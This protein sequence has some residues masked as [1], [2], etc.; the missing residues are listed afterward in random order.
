LR[1]FHLL[2]ELTKRDFLE[3]YVGSVLGIWWSFIWPLVNIFIYTVIFSKVMGAKLP[4]I[5][6]S[7]GYGF[8]LA[9]GLIPWTAFSNSILRIS[10]VFV[11]KSYII[12]KIPI[13]LTIFP[14]SV[15][16]SE[17]ITFLISFTIFVLILLIFGSSPTV[18]WLLIPI[19]YLFQQIFAYSLGLIFA[20]LNV[21]IRDIK[22]VINVVV[23]IWFWF[24][25]IVYVV[26]ILPEVIKKAMILNPMYG[27]IQV[28]QK[29]LVTGEP[30]DYSLLVLYSMVSLTFLFAST[31]IYRKL[32][33]DI[34][35]FL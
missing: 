6:V 2:I 32:E 4:G 21:F 5:S 25:P 23:Q 18:L 8:Y 7:F 30:I 28:Y 35:D 13:P 3:K 34:R 14:L 9:A 1:N 22:E 26:N 24:T 16:L 27:F 20:V 10:N 33:K 11:E 19:A 31:Y 29:T 17:S 12:S 15:I